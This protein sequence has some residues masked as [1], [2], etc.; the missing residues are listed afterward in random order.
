MKQGN[1]IKKKNQGEGFQLDYDQIF[2]DFRILV[3][4]MTQENNYSKI[5]KGLSS[6]KVSKRFFYVA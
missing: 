6:R 4:E 1:M 3:V 2:E 5:Y